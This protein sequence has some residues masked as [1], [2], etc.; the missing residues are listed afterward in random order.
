MSPV[1]TKVSEARLSRRLDKCQM[2]SQTNNY[3]G[4]LLTEVQDSVQIC[5]EWDIEKYV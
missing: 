2:S 1:T 3:E 4:V 5:S